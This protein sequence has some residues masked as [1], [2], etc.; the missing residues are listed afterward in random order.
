MAEHSTEFRRLDNSLGKLSWEAC[1]CVCVCVV[2][3]IFPLGWFPVGCFE[4]LGEV[5]FFLEPPLLGL[6][7]Q[8]GL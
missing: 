2:L 5:K 6:S 7:R 4:K 8:G 3:K 1:V